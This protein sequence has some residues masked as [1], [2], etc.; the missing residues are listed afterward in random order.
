MGHNI[1]ISTEFINGKLIFKWTNVST[2]RNDI[3]ITKDSQSSEWILVYDDQ[4][5]VEDV[6]QYKSVSIKVREYNTSIFTEGYVDYDKIYNVNTV[7]SKEGESK[8]ISWAIQNFPRSGHY[9]IFHAYIGQPMKIIDAAQPV[10][11]NLEKYLYHREPYDSGNI[12][13]VVRN[14]TVK[15]AGYY[16]GSDAQTDAFSGERGVILIVSGKPLKPIIRANLQITAK[17]DTILKCESRST[18]APHYYEKFPPLSYSWFV[19]N[20]KLD[21]EVGE[22]YRFNVSVDAKYNRYSCQAKESLES[23]KSQE[24][25]INPFCK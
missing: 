7:E 4:Y 1:K 16:G 14:I 25:Q 20:T 21:K 19:N 15:D 13:F 6:M 24:I 11:S 8:N 12:L 3:I 22:T 10:S 17:N 18:S 2:I 23:D 5:T 9:F